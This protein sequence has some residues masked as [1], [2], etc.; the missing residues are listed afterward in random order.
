MTANRREDTSVLPPPSKPE[1]DERLASSQYQELRKLGVRKTRCERAN[2]TLQPTALVHE[3]YLKLAEAPSSVW[4]DRTHF[5]AVAARGM[6]QILMDRAPSHRAGKRGAGTL[7]VT[8]DENLVSATQGG[9]DVPAVDEALKRL[10]KLDVRQAKILELHFFAGM[11]FEAA[12]SVLGIS[13]RTAKHDRAM[14][15]AWLRQELSSEL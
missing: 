14:A 8:F 10:A 12:A 5:L 7:Q 2:Q 11:T 9:T 3:T 15:R 6:R 1:V 4:P 13:P